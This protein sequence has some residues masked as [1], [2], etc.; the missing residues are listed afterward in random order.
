[1]RSASHSEE[2]QRRPGFANTGPRQADAPRIF[3]QDRLT[4]WPLLHSA[5]TLRTL[6]AETRMDDPTP[7]DELDDDPCEVLRRVAVFAA[8]H[9]LRE[10]SLMRQFGA[11]LR[12]SQLRRESPRHEGPSARSA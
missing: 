10:A 2:A 4:V 3:P 12:D 5:Q 1:L 9:G 7:S 8:S 6:S 11:Y